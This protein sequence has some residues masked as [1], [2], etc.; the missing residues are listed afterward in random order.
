MY[1]ATKLCVCIIGTTHV[2]PDS[3]NAISDL[4]A[5][6]AVNGAADVQPEDE[7]PDGRCSAL[8]WQRH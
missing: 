1:G 5:D 8:Q 2:G 6:I 4:T 7:W 3:L